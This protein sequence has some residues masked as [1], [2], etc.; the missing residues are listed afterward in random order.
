MR[1]TRQK[2]PYK[3][4]TRAYETETRFSRTVGAPSDKHPRVTLGGLTGE[5]HEGLVTKGINNAETL[6][7]RQGLGKACGPSVFPVPRFLSSGAQSGPYVS[8][9]S[10]QS[11]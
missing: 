9:V 5:G 2:P 4:K 7:R 10:Q 6:Q 3:F 11:Q 1:P 8:G